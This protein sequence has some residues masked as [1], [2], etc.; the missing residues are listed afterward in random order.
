MKSPKLVGIVN[1]TPDSFSGDGR[2]GSDALN[3]ANALIATGADLLD[4]GAES[5]RPGATPLS[6]EEE[7]N[8]LSPFLE[9]YKGKIG[10]SIDTYHAANATRLS[11]HII[12]DVSG[13]RDPAMLSALAGS[14]NAII[15]M[16]SLSVPADKSIVWPADINPVAEILKWKEEVTA[17]AEATGITAERLIFDPGLGFGKTLEQS[18]ALALAAR[19]LVA[20]GGRW[21]IGHS[22]KSF[23]SLFSD[24]P[25]ADRD[26]LTLVFSAMLADAGVHYLRVHN[27]E[28]HRKLFGRLCM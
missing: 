21:L 20:S 8:R 22:R 3:H 1:L 9:S 17:R 19:E 23:L 12:N 7:W 14:K 27:V 2:L 25:T 15:V 11:A 4:I 5:T 13:L 28:A 10:L 24:A 26:A 6:A 16:H 18:L